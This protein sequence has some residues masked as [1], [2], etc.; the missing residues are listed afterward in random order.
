MC[1]MFYDT[2]PSHSINNIKMKQ[3]DR[4]KEDYH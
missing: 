4:D 2:G 1:K 3:G